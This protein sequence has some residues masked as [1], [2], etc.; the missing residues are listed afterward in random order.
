MHEVAVH[1]TAVQGAILQDG[2]YRGRFPVFRVNVF[3]EATVLSA[4]D[5]SISCHRM[6]NNVDVDSEISSI[7]VA[8]SCPRFGRIAICIL[9]MCYLAMCYLADGRSNMDAESV[10]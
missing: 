1:R 5:Q 10:P 6:F 7:D 9:A 8:S 2:C 3:A 4:R